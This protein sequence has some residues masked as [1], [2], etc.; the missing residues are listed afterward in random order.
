MKDIILLIKQRKAFFMTVLVLTLFLTFGG[1]VY[2][3]SVETKALGINLDFE[4]ATAEQV[5]I[6]LEEHLGAFQNGLNSEGLMRGFLNNYTYMGY[7]G[8]NFVILVVMIFSYFNMSDVRTREFLETLPVKRVALELYHY[9]ALIGI[10]LL[11]VIVTTLIHLVCFSN[12]NHKILS[13]AERFPQLLGHVVP[14]NLV[15]VNNLSLLYQIGMMTLFLFAMLTFL[16]VFTT[17][18]KKWAVGLPIGF[19]LWQSM[20]DFMYDVRRIDNGNDWRDIPDSFRMKAAVFEP[21]AYFDRYDWNGEI[22]TNPFTS[23]VATALCIMILLMIGLLIAHAYFRE[24]SKGKVFY[25]NF[26]NIAL[27]VLGGFRLFVWA[28]DW[29]LLPTAIIIT[30]VAEIVT[31]YFLYHKKNRTFKLAVKENKKVFNPVLALGVKSYLIATGIITL[32]VQTIDV[33]ENLEGL[34]DSFMETFI[35]VGYEPWYLEY[36][37]MGYRF[38]YAIFIIAGFAVFKCIQFAMERTKASREFY[39][40]LPVSRMKVYCSKILMDLGVVIIPLLVF[41]LTSVGYLMYFNRL[42]GNITPGFDVMSLVGDQFLLVGIMLCIAISVMGVMY[43]ID[44]VTVSGGLKNIYCGVVLVFGLIASVLILEEFPFTIFYD[45]VA[46]IWGYTQ[47][48]VAVI[49]LIIGAALLVLAGYLYIKRDKAKEIFYYKPAKYVFAI[50]LSLSYLF[51]VLLCASLEQSVI[52][53]FLAIIGTVLIFF[54]TI[55]YCS[56]EH[57][58]ELQ[59]KFGKKKT[60]K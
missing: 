24:L 46:L 35:W 43:L 34:R 16:F 27:L 48:P 22:C 25:I 42:M 44:A 55:Y 20:S 8:V 56:P 26:L 50:L 51:V 15:L 52:Q 28:K 19:V 2:N 7:V 17:I 60:V 49:Y 57:M 30:L 37:E 40:T 29:F 45:F 5:E 3:L 14:D 39:E 59:K 47:T 54:L 33:V 1:A 6:A 38:Q 11:N 58:T 41:T 32:I 53:Y 18:F 12:Y 23:Y 4:L 36:F 21:K 13:L 31:A 10:F 9:V